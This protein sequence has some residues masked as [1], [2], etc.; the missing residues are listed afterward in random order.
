M[1]LLVNSAD[2]SYR[3]RPRYVP[4]GFLFQQ[5]DTYLP[6]LPPTTCPCPIHGLAKNAC[7]QVRNRWSEIRQLLVS[8]CVPLGK[9]SPHTP[10]HFCNPP[11]PSSSSLLHF[12]F[13]E[14][15]ERKLRRR[16][17]CECLGGGCCGQHDVGLS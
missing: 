1:G 8:S 16:Q 15:T 12:C 5:R 10:K 2:T 13:S 3:I 17:R 6:R 11:P 9:T 4:P 14:K 7:V